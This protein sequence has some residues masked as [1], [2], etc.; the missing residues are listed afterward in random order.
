[1]AGD[2]VGTARGRLLAT[3]AVV[4]LS[5]TFGAPDAFAKGLS[6][7][8]VAVGFGRVWTTNEVGVLRINPQSGRP[9]GPT[10]PRAG[11]SLRLAAGEGAVWVLERP[12]LHG[13]GRL[14]ALDPRTLRPRGAPTVVGRVPVALAL[15]TGAVWVANYLD[16]TL[17]RIDAR[18]RRQPSPEVAVG[19]EPQDVAVG[20]GAVWVTVVGPTRRGPGGTEQPLGPG[21]LV[22]ADPRTGKVVARVRIP[23]NPGALS[24]SGHS[25][26][27]LGGRNPGRSIREWT[28]LTRVD[29]RTNRVLA[30]RRLPGVVQDLVAAPGALWLISPGRVVGCCSI[31]NAGGQLERLDSATGRVTSRWLVGAQAAAVALGDGGV[32]VASPGAA[33]LNRLV[34][35]RL[36]TIRIPF[37]RR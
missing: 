28:L 24:V 16:G 31:S 6:A 21:T 23:A 37:F 10:V 11:R 30:T 26:W 7:N 35:H 2:C 8:D 22:R 33:V 27:I 36:R 12:T 13:R 3:L 4:A 5:S 18:T 17:T 15:G 14:V 9:V 25:V 19:L 34:G 1:M 32:W 20:A 29:A